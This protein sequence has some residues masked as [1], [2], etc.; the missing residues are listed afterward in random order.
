MNSRLVFVAVAFSVAVV[1]LSSLGETA[2]YE[3][4]ASDAFWIFESNQSDGRAAESIAAAGDVNGDGYDDLIV[5]ARFYDNGAENA[6]VAWVFYGGD[7]GYGAT[8]DV[9]L[10]P[11]SV[12]QHGF[13]G[14]QVAGAGDVNGDGYDDV[15][16][17]MMNWDQPSPFFH[18]EGAVFVYY[19]GDGALDPTHDWWCHAGVQWAHLGWG[20]DTAGDVNGDGYDDIIVGGFDYTNFYFEA[21][22]VFHG[23]VNGLNPDGSR[24]VGTPANADWLVVSDQPGAYFG[25]RVGTAGDVNGDGY[26]EVVVGAYRYD[27]GQTDEGVLFLWQG[28]VDGL[29]PNT[30]AATADWKAESDQIDAFLT[31]PGEPSDMGTAGDVNGDGYDD[32]IVGTW[33]YDSVHDADGIALLF[34]G[35]ADGLGSDGNP[36]NADWVATGLYEADCV[37]GHLARAGDFNGDGL[38]DIVIGAQN[39]DGEGGGTNIGLATIWYG[40]TTGL[41]REGTPYYANVMIEGEQDSAVFSRTLTAAGDVNDDGFDDLAIGSFYYD[42]GQTDEGAVFAFYG[43]QVTF[44]DDFETGD[45]LRWPREAP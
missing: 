18:D 45:T 9:T 1:G 43:Q 44:I 38:D 22:L 11:P 14:Y 5:G 3:M 30:D 7:N 28:S 6:G 31:G 20:M 33:S 16:V 13:F 2:G 26:D 10:N 27:N 17:G 37:G 35:S 8:P 21:A 25:T 4:S 41:P 39:W 42:G 32:L 29:G 12:Q 24:P 15:M 23:S 40:N 36:S 19:G 34:Y